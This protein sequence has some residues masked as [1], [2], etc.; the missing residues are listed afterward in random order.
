VEV[1]LMTGHTQVSTLKRYANLR[2]RILAEKLD[3]RK[4]TEKFQTNK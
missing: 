3:G 1:M 4:F 2:Q